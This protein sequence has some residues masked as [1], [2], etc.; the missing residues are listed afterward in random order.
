MNRVFLDTG[1]DAEPGGAQGRA[2]GRPHLRQQR[3][4]ARPRDRRQASRRHDRAHGARQ[5]RLPHRAALAGRGRSSRAG[6]ERQGGEGVRARP[7]TAAASTPR[8]SSPPIRRGWVLLRAWND[9]ADP[10]VLD[11]YP[12]ATT[13]PV[14]LELPG[15]LPPDPADARLFRRLARP[16][17]SP[18]PAPA[19]TSALRRSATPFSTICARRVPD[20]RA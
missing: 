20:M 11:I 17:R 18:T 1:G 8:A 6:A 12:Y 16:R 2:Q 3:P 9:G 19:R 15:G 13:S 14:Y 10:Q 4:A 5:A 7:A